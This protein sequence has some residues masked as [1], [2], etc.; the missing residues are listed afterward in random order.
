[1]G[2]GSKSTLGMVGPIEWVKTV[3]LSFKAYR[4]VAPSPKSGGQRLPNEHACAC[5]CGGQR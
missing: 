5:L 2:G 3:L 1:M 4:L